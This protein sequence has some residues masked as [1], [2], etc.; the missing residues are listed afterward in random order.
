MEKLFEQLCICTELIEAGVA[1]HTCNIA[2]LNKFCATFHKFASEFKIYL[3]CKTDLTRYNKIQME[4][5]YL[6][7]TQVLTCITNLER[8]MHTERNFE[9]FAT[10]NH[11]INRINWCLRLLHASLSQLSEDAQ[12]DLNLDDLSFVELL[13]VV[14]DKLETFNEIVPELQH[15]VSIRSLDLDGQFHDAINHIIRH[16]LAFANVA[17]EADKKALNSLCQRVLDESSQFEH[18]FEQHSAEERKL[19]SLALQRCIYCLETYL[20]EALLRLVFA[21]LLDVEEMSVKKL[22]T[23]LETKENTTLVPQLIAELDLN[24]DRIQQIG[25]FAIA[26]SQEAKTKTIVRSCLASLEAL[27]S[28][29]VPAFQL[30]TTPSAVQ[31]AD[32][33]EQ[34]FNEEL[35]TFRNIIHE[36]IDS[37][38]LIS[39]YLDLLAD[40]IQNAEQLY[41][42]GELLQIARMGNVIL[43]HFQLEENFQILSIDGIRLYQDFLLILGECQAVLE[44]GTSVDLKRIVKRF[45]ILYSI[46]AKL[47][48]DLWKNANQV[49]ASL[50][51][52][53]ITNPNQSIY[54]SKRQI[55]FAKQRSRKY[56]KLINNRSLLPFH[57]NI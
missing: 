29:L 47:R 17:L 43:Q 42:S 28:V 21:S 46:L 33:L 51:D 11:F 48:E 27:D 7:F 38:A 12:L 15:S 50:N 16:A 54:C 49:N 5:I 26:F 57:R 55:S 4:T 35:M 19:E 25:V 9:L 40:S 20:N 3:P 10:R 2:W 24:M 23:A 1:S 34:H 56:Y 45:K 53:S 13:D 44:L 39:N 6:C 52:K 8:I 30:Q 31:H 36:I 14:L 37:Q 32:L 41:P 22:K 18:N